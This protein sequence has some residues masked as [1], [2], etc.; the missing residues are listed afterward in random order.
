MGWDREK[1]RVDR[2]PYRYIYFLS[3]PVSTRRTEKAYFQSAFGL[4]TNQNWLVGQRYFSDAEVAEALERTKCEN[5]EL[6][7]G[8]EATPASGDRT[9]VVVSLPRPEAR[10]IVTQV[11]ASERDIVAKEPIAPPSWL[12]PLAE[13]IELLQ[14]DADNQERDH[15]DLVARFFEVL[16]YRR[17]REIKFRR[18]RIDVV[19]SKEDAPLITIEVKQDWSLSPGSIDAVNQAYRYAH[20]IG[21]RYVIV[22]NGDRYI[23]Y[24]RDNPVDGLGRRGYTYDEHLV[25]NFQLTSLREADLASIVALRKGN[26][27]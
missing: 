24:D 20:E 1:S 18:G 23:V 10:R 17:I 2:R 22:T 6:L 7:L 26:L 3:S 5:V 12:R 21:T 14:A 19:I 9:S 4:K 27:A 15:E 8:I 13:D 11:R 16:G 25:A